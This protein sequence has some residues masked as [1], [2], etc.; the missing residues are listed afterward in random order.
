MRE[1]LFTVFVLATIFFVQASPSLGLS[2]NWFFSVQESGFRCVD[3]ILPDDAG[4]MGTGTHEY[5]IRC[6]PTE[7]CISWGTTVTEEAVV[8]SENNTGII[9]V[10]FIVP[11]GKPIGNCSAPMTISVESLELGISGSWEGGIC[12]SRYDD[13]DSSEREGGQGVGD[14]LSDNF[15]LFDIGFSQPRVFAG[16]GEGI[17]YRLFIESYAET[18]VD[19]HTSVSLSRETPNASV[20]YSIQGISLEGNYY[21]KIDA[22]ARDCPESYCTKSTRGMIV[23]SDDPE[24]SGEGFSLSLFP[25][26]INVKD[27]ESVAFRL[28]VQNFG[29]RA[30][31]VPSVSIEPE[32]V[33]T[34]SEEPIDLEN[35]EE[36]TRS[37]IVRPSNTS[38]L[39]E[40]TVSVEGGNGDSKRV[41]SYLSTNEMITDVIRE[42]DGI[43]DPDRLGEV[44][45]DLD[46]WYQEYRDSDYGSDLEGY[47]SLKDALAAAGTEPEQD[48]T[49]E[50]PPPPP[51]DNGNGEEPGPGLIWLV[52]VIIAVVFVL[53]M[54]LWS[55]KGKGSGGVEPDL[56]Q[57]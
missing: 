21:L 27:L 16:T 39:Y 44:S 5:T 3:V 47:S 36:I 28:S 46:Q 26:S 56:F 52:P 43:E 51:P 48:G 1:I 53:A 23:V 22:R 34:F 49:V 37:F 30:D 50:P 7:E 9:P 41:T 10:C 45:D 11:E 8:A 20:D 19:L 12:V 17:T 25:Q 2:S 24:E 13:F 15:D 18:P 40:I 31:F 32:A 29:E 54:V 57:R 6:E 38:T 4:Y 35:M 55:R 42:K 14:V 33:N